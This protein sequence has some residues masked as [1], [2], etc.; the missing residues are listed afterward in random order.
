[1]NVHFFDISM[2]SLA[3]GSGK[4][5]KTDELV[6]KSFP[7]TPKKALMPSPDLLRLLRAYL[8]ISLYIYNIDMS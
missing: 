4:T 3:G 7:T 1:M 5:W 8:I 2:V 6:G